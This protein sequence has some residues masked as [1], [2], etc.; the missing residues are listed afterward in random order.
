MGLRVKAQINLLGE[1]MDYCAKNGPD[2]V[3]GQPLRR[4]AA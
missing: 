2:T 1:K 4:Q 3:D